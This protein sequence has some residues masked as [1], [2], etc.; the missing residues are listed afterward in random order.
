MVCIICGGNHHTRQCVFPLSV[1]RC[2]CSRMV[3]GPEENHECVNNA[4]KSYRLDVC[5]A[6]TKPFLKMRVLDSTNFDGAEVLF[7]NKSN[8]RFE[9]FHNAL[10]LLNA[11][12]SGVFNI[13]NN[14]NHFIVD[15][16]STKLVN[17]NFFIALMEYR[18]TSIGLRVIV[19]QNKVVAL[20]KCDVKMTMHYGKLLMPPQYHMNS[21]IILGLKPRSGK[22][23]LQIKS[24]GLKT[25]NAQWQRNLGWNID[26]NIDADN[27]E[28]NTIT[29]PPS[30]TGLCVNCNGD[31][32]IKN[33]D[34]PLYSMHCY[35]CLV[36]SFDGTN[37]VNPCRPVNRKASI[38]S[39]LL[40]SEA[41]TLFE[42]AYNT[43]EANLFYLN[44]SRFVQVTPQQKMISAPVEG[45]LNVKQNGDFQYIDFKQTKFN[46]CSF[47]IA[48]LDA[49]GIWRLRFRL[50]ITP[51]HG[52][53]VFKLTKT[54]NVNNGRIEIPNDSMVNTVAVFG[55]TNI[56][57]SFYITLRIHA[58]QNGQISTTPFDGYVGYIGFNIG[59]SDIGLHIDEIFDKDD[60]NIIQFNKRLY[61]R[62]NEQPLSTFQAQRIA[63]R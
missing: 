63:P 33:C 22:L 31:H 58:N 35:G 43:T 6:T 56:E 14:E 30:I 57:P 4:L 50:V 17:F 24:S 42:L 59:H 25:I 5:A 39:D 62:E 53:V 28:S 51:K 10:D 18:G 38:K 44:E 46:R 23:L 19:K 21:S 7:F 1:S 49:G 8:G 20:V 55:F 15:Y 9:A 37:H 52:L 45:L 26:A 48:V 36:V 32:N 29:D 61:K 47:L 34:L 2:G 11:A 41:M 54:L 40:A 60:G 3:F 16:Q 13:I 12:T 27:M